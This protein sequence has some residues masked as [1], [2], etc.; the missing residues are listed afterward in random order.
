MPEEERSPS[1]G[2]VAALTSES[3]APRR[4]KSVPPKARMP[5]SAVGD[6]SPFMTWVPL[7]PCSQRSQTPL[8]CRASSS[9]DCAMSEPVSGLSRVSSWTWER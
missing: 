9:S 6:G 4:S 2:T 8:F 1:V 7:A 5:A 3:S